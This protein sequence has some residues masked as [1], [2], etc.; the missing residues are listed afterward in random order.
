MPSWWFDCV[1]WFVFDRVLWKWLGMWSTWFVKDDWNCMNTGH[2]NWWLPYKCGA[3]WLTSEFLM[4]DSFNLT[5]ISSVTKCF[6]LSVWDIICFYILILLKY[7]KSCQKWIDFS[8]SWI[9]YTVWYKLL[10]HMIMRYAVLFVLIILQKSKHKIINTSH[11][12][13]YQD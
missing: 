2:E 8:H 10:L 6:K 13:T 3:C 1:V 11:K 4:Q 7:Y 9:Y 12:Y 5:K